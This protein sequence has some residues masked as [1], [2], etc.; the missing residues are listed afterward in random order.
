MTAVLADR[1][2]APLTLTAVQVLAML[3]RN[4]SELTYETLQGQVGISRD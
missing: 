3:C 1:F 2:A 4:A